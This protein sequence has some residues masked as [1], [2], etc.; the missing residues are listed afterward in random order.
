MKMLKA[1]AIVIVALMCMAPSMAVNAI[2]QFN[3]TPGPLAW[4]LAGAAVL[5]VLLA[6]SSPF[7]IQGAFQDRR[8]GLFM[9]A[10][11]TCGVRVVQPRQ[12]H[13]SGVDHT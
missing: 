9:V 13:R 5:S 8:W 6:G 12:R 1:A 2:H 3:H 10:L 11:F 4:P 7:A